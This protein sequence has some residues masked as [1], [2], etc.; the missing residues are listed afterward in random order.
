MKDQKTFL[1]KISVLCHK[2]VDDFR[3]FLIKHLMFFVSETKVSND[4]SQNTLILKSN[5]FS[6][7]KQLYIYFQ[8]QLREISEVKKLLLKLVGKCFSF[9]KKDRSIVLY[10]WQAHIS[11][12]LEVFHCLSEL[13]EDNVVVSHRRGDWLSLIDA[14]NFFRCTRRH[15]PSSLSGSLLSPSFC[16]WYY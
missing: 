3:K 7:N 11:S 8:W 4:W 15:Q 2:I 1:Q 5:T 16:C 14:G 13:Y 10:C 6:R 12:K 9:R